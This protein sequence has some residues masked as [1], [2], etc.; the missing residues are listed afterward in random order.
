MLF[1][2]WLI[3][4][5]RK[6]SLVRFRRVDLRKRS[7]TRHHLR[8]VVVCS[9][10]NF[11]EPRILLSSQSAIQT[12]LTGP[13]LTIPGDPSQSVAT[14]F[15]FLSKSAVYRNEFGIVRVD[16]SAGHIGA[17]APGQPGYAQ[18]AFAAGRYEMLFCEWDRKPPATVTINLTGGS[19]YVLYGI[20]NGT[21]ANHISRNLTNSVALSLPAFFSISAANPDGGFGHFRTNSGV[22]Q[23]EDRLYGGDQDFNDAVLSVIAETPP[24]LSTIVFGLSHDTGISAVDHLT[25][26]PSMNGTV[27][28]STGPVTLQA[29]FVTGNST[30]VFKTVVSSIQP[31]NFSLSP[32]QL[33]SIL[34]RTFTDGQYDLV[35]P[36]INSSNQISSNASLSFTLDTKIAPPIARATVS[37]TGVSKS[38]GL[39]LPM[40]Q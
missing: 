28:S 32:N 6:L 5:G 1:C 33:S 22:Y 7:R 24:T 30:P 11:L 10:V 15:N 8:K 20:Q 26:D 23:F 3:D 36:T 12:V 2:N 29:A 40:I 18:A 19:H 27:T 4:L 39:T 17:L 21:T 31:G 13:V 37:D 35:L 34:G 16:D 25:N 38:D 9:A 14:T